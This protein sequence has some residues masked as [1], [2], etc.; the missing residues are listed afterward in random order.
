MNIT[1][2]ER[3]NVNDKLW[4]IT[5]YYNP[6]NYQ[7]R[8]STY[9]KFMYTLKDSNVNVLTIECAFDDDKFSLPNDPRIIKM[10]SK[11]LLWQK[12]RLLNIAA[13][14]LPDECKYI[15]WIDCDIVFKN[16]NWVN[17]TIEVLQTHH[18]AQLF[19]YC[20]KLE[21]GD[22][23]DYKNQMNR[24]YSFASVTKRDFSVMNT[25]RYDSHGHT[26]YA[27]AATREFF[28]TVGLYEYAISGSADHFMAH[29]VYNN[30]NHCITNALKFDNVQI[31]HLKEYGKRFYNLVKGRIGCVSGEIYHLWH[32]S[33]KNRNYFSRMWEITKFGY[34][35]NTDLISR[36]DCPLEWTLDTLKNKTELVNYFNT[37][38]ESRREDND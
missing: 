31:D 21:K 14:L 17:E 19:E 36:P 15:A 24:S 13:N 37:Y 27:W 26:G 16:T 20:T 10:R 22:I 33:T 29:C 4:V 23:L 34:N 25:E 2:Y 8:R 7:S 12:E 1:G 11:S 35:P 5:V 38:F 3:Y 6:C 28:D 32:G 30:F 18:I 9:D